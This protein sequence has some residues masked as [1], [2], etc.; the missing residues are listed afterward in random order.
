MPRVKQCVNDIPVNI[1]CLNAIEY[2]NV[3]FLD[4]SDVTCGY[5]INENSNL[6]ILIE[7]AIEKEFS[8]RIVSRIIY[9][10]TLFSRNQFLFL[11]N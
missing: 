11:I 3:A 1:H 2:M 9:T 6:G 10:Q 7:P 8:D 4:L 5:G